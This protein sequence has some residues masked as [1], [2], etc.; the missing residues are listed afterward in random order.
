MVTLHTT[1]L[2]DKPLSVSLPCQQ[3]S[4]SRSRPKSSVP[5][6]DSSMGAATS[7]RPSTAWATSRSSRGG[8]VDG[9][10]RNVL[11]GDRRGCVLVV[12][13]DEPML[14]WLVGWWEGVCDDRDSFLQTTINEWNIIG[15]VNVSSVKMFKHRINKYLWRAGYTVMKNVRLSI[16][17]WLPCP[18]AIWAFVLDG[19]RVKT[20]SCVL[21]GCFQAFIARSTSHILNTLRSWNFS[22]YLLNCNKLL[23]AFWSTVYTVTFYLIIGW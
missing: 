5:K 15:C 2:P 1:V 9:R 18:L 22:V 8:W 6:S 16:S 21:T 13:G 7:K 3:S 12:S 4:G 19:N 10:R 20:N 14:G 11:V 23:F 17:Q